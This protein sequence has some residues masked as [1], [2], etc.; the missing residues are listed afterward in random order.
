VRVGVP[1]PACA[2]ELVR[3]ELTTTAA[4]RLAL[5][6]GVVDSRTA[7]D[8]GVLDEL[9]D[10]P[11]VESRALEVAEELSGLPARAYGITKAALR[12]D[13]IGRMQRATEQVDPVLRV[14]L[15]E[16]AS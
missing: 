15:G 7:L 9:A 1:Y 16:P 10:P 6:A 13:A 8:L 5:S 4:R 12:A 14:W 3:S 11:D 2:L